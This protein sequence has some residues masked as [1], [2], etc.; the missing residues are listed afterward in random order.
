MAQKK[1][2]LG[3]DLTVSITLNGSVAAQFDLHTDTHIQPMFT[4]R[5]VI[6]TNNGGVTVAR[7]VFNGWDV[8]LTYMRQDGIP[9][10][11][12]QF[13]QDVYLSGNPDINVSMQQTVR[14]DDGSVD[15]F[16]Y[17]DGIIYPTDAGSYKGNEDVSGSFKMFFPRRLQT[18]GGPNTTY[19]GS[20]TTQF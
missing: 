19:S 15:V 4:E 3:R 14:N 2:N 10:T 5:K 13:T 7:P 6:P 11:V 18:A 12:Q 17:I 1:Q 8:T 9:D 16:Q 20:T